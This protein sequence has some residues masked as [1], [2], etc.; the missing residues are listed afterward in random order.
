MICFKCG[1]L[2]NESATVYQNAMP[3]SIDYIGRSGWSSDDDNC[4]NL[5]LTKNILLMV[6][7]RSDCNEHNFANR[8]ECYRCNTPRGYS[9]NT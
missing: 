5:Y 7:N 4:K 8:G 9:T 1:A 6:L 3:C 2:R